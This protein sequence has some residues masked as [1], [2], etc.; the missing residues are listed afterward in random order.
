MMSVTHNASAGVCGSGRRDGRGSGWIAV[1]LLTRC[2]AVLLDTSAR[3]ALARS[4]TRVG[5]ALAGVAML[6]LLTVS[7]RAG[8]ADHDRGHPVEQARRDLTGG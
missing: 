2:M 3:E 6:W 7:C 5:L 8:L 1:L 4:F